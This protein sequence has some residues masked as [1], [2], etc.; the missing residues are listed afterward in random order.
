[1]FKENDIDKPIIASCMTGMT[2]TSLAFA[3]YLVGLKNAS[4]YY[5]SWTEY[6]QQTSE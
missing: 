6:S 2:A 3:A 5:G 1:M 4:V